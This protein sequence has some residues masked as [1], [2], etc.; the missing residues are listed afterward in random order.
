MQTEEKQNFM[1]VLP[2]LK[3]PREALVYNSSPRGKVR[4]LRI[5][6]RMK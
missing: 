3:D 4:S 5:L 6:Q 2:F 1:N